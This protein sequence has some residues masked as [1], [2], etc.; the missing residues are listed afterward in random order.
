VI[1]DIRAAGQT[2]LRAIAAELNDRWIGTRQGGACH[3]SSVRNLLARLD[4]MAADARDRAH[5]A[6]MS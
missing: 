3:V 5:A 1:S 4:A 6:L 2:S